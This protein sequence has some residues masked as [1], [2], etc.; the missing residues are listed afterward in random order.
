MTGRGVDQVL[1]HPGDPELREAHATRATAYVRLAAKA[2]GRI[3]APV[4]PTYVWG[5]GLAI[6][7]Q[8]QPAA[9][10]VNLE[11]S[12]TNSRDFRP[13]KG[14]HHRMSPDNIDC[15]RAAHL[16]VCVL[17]NNHVLDFGR[18]GL[19]QTLQTLQ[20]VGIG[21]AGAG[22]NLVEATRPARVTLGHGR[23]LWV[24]ALGSPSSGIP[25]DWAASTTRPGLWLLREPTSAVADAIAKQARLLAR[26]G[27]VALVSIHWGSNWGEEI[28][29]EHVDFAHRLVDGGIAVVHGHSSHHVRAIELYRGRP[30]F[31]GMGDLI[32]DYE[33][34]CTPSRWRSDLGV[35]GMVT[36]S[37]EAGTLV[38]LRLYPMRMCRMQLRRADEPDRR[39]L[40]E[41]LD[42]MSEPFGARFGEDADGA[43][44]LRG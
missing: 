35:M 14:A 1:P 28:P 4:D 32:T 36:L 24:F 30:I 37:P 38:E 18:M 6:L 15:L 19:L 23:T 42:R 20:R 21:Y 44:V 11:T 33:G 43:I 7:Q 29:Q 3:L 5:D 40:A 39:W 2:H 41:A 8:H 27:D 26:P 17:A 9:S 22:R 16:D 31:Y 34:I 25:W 12:I 10:V 13:G